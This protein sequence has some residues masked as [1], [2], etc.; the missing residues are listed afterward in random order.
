M[1]VCVCVWERERERERERGN[2]RNQTKY[3]W[4]KINWQKIYIGSNLIFDLFI[5]YFCQHVF[6]LL[7][8]GKFE[9]ETRVG[10]SNK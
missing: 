3:M 5:Y 6:Q 8:A 1:C 9:V 10:K 2:E 4:K 7:D